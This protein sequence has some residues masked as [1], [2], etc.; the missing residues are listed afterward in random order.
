MEKTRLEPNTQPIYCHFNLFCGGG[1][2][3][4]T[5]K[6]GPAPALYLHLCAKCASE[7]VETWPE[8]LKPA[9]EAEKDPFGTLG[10]AYWPDE[11][12]ESAAKGVAE[13]SGEGV[14]PC[15]CGYHPTGKT[16]KALM[17]R[18]Q[19]ACEVYKA[20]KEG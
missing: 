17:V 14:E 20:Q 6:R 13:A 1:M 19:K 18:H 4:W 5:L 3:K 15:V 9:V 12:G 11:D 16:A 10:K 2:A 8:A 7:V